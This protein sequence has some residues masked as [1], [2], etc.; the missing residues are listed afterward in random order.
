MGQEREYFMGQVPK[1][2]T[3]GQ[4]DAVT[5][6]RA[7]LR[8]WTYGLYAVVAESGDRRGIFT[9]NWCSQVS[10]D[11]PLVILA[12]ERES[13]TLALIRESGLVTVCPFRT[14]QRELA[15]ALGRPALRAGDKFALPGV[16][17]VPTALGPPA[18]ASSL[19]YVVGRV[20]RIDEA[21][22]SVLIVAEVI[23]ADT[24]SGDLPLTMR[25]AGFRH[26]G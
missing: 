13:S 8:Q 3:P 25:E 10:F 12:V 5:S 24:F 23:E 26:A 22:D 1:V 20:Q 18:L 19:G 4:S 17:T 6:R 11:P 21:G 14:G 16:E 2:S 15:G 7:A 9:A